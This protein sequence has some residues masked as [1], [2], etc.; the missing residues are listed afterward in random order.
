M[1]DP[2]SG[3]LVALWDG[4]TGGKTLDAMCALEKI[5]LRL[6]DKKSVSDADIAALTKW[7]STYRTVS[8]RPQLKPMREW[9]IKAMSDGV[10]DDEEKLDLLAWGRW[11]KDFRADAGRRYSENAKNE[12]TWRDHPPTGRQ[13]EFLSELGASKSQCANLTKGTASDLIEQLLDKRDNHDSE[14]DRPSKRQ[15]KKDG[16]GN[17]CLKNSLIVAVL[18]IVVFYFMLR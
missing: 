2:R 13:L 6:D 4:V 16:N 17:G 11:M 1:N 18:I 14:D 12:I 3:E 8:G 15:E 10:I 5:L 9:L 7:L